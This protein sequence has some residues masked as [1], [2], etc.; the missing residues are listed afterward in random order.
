MA[1]ITFHVL[2]LSDILPRY[3]KLINLQLQSAIVRKLVLTLHL[4]HAYK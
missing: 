2:L 1:K 4:P 3:L